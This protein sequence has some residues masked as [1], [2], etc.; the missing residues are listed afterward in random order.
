MILEFYGTYSAFID[1][2]VLGIVFG[3]IYDIFRMIRIS[4]IPCLAPQGK[5]YEFVKIPEKRC[6]KSKKRKN[7]FFAFSD[8]VLTFIE[9]I[10][11]WLIISAGEILFIYHVNGGVVRIYF[12]V[13]TFIGAAL[14]F[15][16]IGKIT[17]YFSVRIIFLIRCLLY[18]SFYIIIYP[19]RMFGILLENIAKLL[20]NITFMPLSKAIETR[21]SK[22]YS[23]KR[24]SHILTQSKKG[25]FIYD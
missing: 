1:A 22:I 16:T 17:M 12:V 2:F 21:R 9:D 20:W 11:F 15:F 4:R 18:W 14:Y 5:F 10:I 19:V 7:I 8:A 3:V 13:F 24:I 25:F 6:A 23:K